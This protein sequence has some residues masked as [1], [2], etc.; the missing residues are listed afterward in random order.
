[1]VAADFPTGSDIV[2]AVPLAPVRFKAPRWR[3]QALCSLIRRY[4]SKQPFL[5]TGEVKLD[6]EWMIHEQDRHE[7]PRSPDLDNILK[8]MLDALQGPDGVMVNDS[9]VQEISCRWIDWTSREQRFDLRIRYIEDEWAEK[10]GLMF[11][12]MTANLCLPLD[13]TLP[14]ATL[15][16]ILEV[17]EQQF[18]ARQQMLTAT[19]D[20][21]TA[22]RVMSVRRPFHI[23]RVTGFSTIALEQIRSELR[24]ETLSGRKYMKGK[25]VARK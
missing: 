15:L 24:N 22:N 5:L 2:I 11:V 9:Q 21:Y 23:S 19:G 14:A 10:E 1:M 12:R 6:I 25:A 13:R 20:Y 7:T 3:K 4:T 8:P 18:A 17:S 16:K